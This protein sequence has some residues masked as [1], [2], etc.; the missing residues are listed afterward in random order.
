MI[1]VQ[2]PNCSSLF[3]T[4]EKYA[5]KTATCLTCQTRFPIPNISSKSTNQNKKSDQ[6][7]ESPGVLQQGHGGVS[8]AGFICGIVA[9]LLPFIPCLGLLAGLSAL[10]GIICS[11]IG[12]VQAKKEN[13]KR[14]LAIA[15]LICSIFAIIWIPLLILVIFGSAASFFSLPSGF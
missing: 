8:I 7:S 5:G 9:I 1:R 14:S 3:D 6:E 11:I 13:R 15:G 2:C 10:A 4:D 12:L